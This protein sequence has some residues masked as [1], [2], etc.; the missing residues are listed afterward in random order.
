MHKSSNFLP[1][2][3]RVIHKGTGERGTVSTT[4]TDDRGLWAGVAWDNPDAL[5]LPHTLHAEHLMWSADDAAQDVTVDIEGVEVTA[6]LVTTGDG[7]RVNL[8]YLGFPD[9]S[10]AGLRA[11]AGLCRAAADRADGAL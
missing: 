8:V 3:T 11:F 5:E 6:S 2:G 7:P 10:P 9:W 1:V 4:G